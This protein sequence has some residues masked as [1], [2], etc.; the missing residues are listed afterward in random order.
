MRIT[1]LFKNPGYIPSD[2]AIFSYSVWYVS[3]PLWNVY[4]FPA[5]SSFPSAL[6]FFLSLHVTSLLYLFLLGF[7]CQ[8]HVC[9]VRLAVC[10]KSCAPSIVRSI[11]L[12]LQKRKSCSAEASTIYESHL[13]R[14]KV[15]CTNI[16]CANCQAHC[17]ARAF[18]ARIL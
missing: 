15:S 6:Y 14:T 7:G 17:A 1:V 9:A 11:P 10:A 8:S 2:S 16:F 13:H 4:K 3:S 12:S 5:I 18:D